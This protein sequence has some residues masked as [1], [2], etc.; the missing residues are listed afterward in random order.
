MPLPFSSFLEYLDGVLR[1]LFPLLFLASCAP[2][3]VGVK[4]LS[5]GRGNLSST[6]VGSPDPEQ[7]NPPK[8]QKLFITY[9]IPPSRVRNAPML[10][11]HVIF[12]NY[13]EEVITF[14][15]HQQSGNFLYELMNEKFQEKGGFLTYKAE[16]VNKEGEVLADWRQQMWVEL[17]Q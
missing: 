7:E 2:Y 17:I 11:L 8:G 15:I 4:R 9:R 16:L 13:T 6:W 5:Y 10:S 12:R 1:Y 14:P 3:S